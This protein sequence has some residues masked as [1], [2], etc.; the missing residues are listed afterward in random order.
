MQLIT[1]VAVVGYLGQRNS[2]NAVQDLATQLMEKAA[3]QVSLELQDYLESPHELQ[4]TILDAAELGFLDWSNLP[5]SGKYLWKKIQ[6]FDAVSYVGYA[7]K[8]GSFA[9]AGEFL[10]GQGVTIDE[11]SPATDGNNHTFSTNELGERTEVVKIYTPEE[12]TPQTDEWFT[13]TWEKQSPTWGSIYVWPDDPDVVTIPFSQPILDQQNQPIGVLNTDISLT[14]ISQFLQEIDLS[15]SSEIFIL[16]RNGQLV[17][18]SEPGN[19]FHMVD[20]QAQR[21][22]AIDSKNPQIQAVANFLTTQFPNLATLDNAEFLKFKALDQVQYAKVMPWQNDL[23][24]DWLVVATLPESDFMAQIHAN[25]RK[26]FWLCVGAAFLSSLLGMWTANRL[27]SPILTLRDAS[28]NFSKGHPLEKMPPSHI[29]EL[30]DLGN[31][32]NQMAV[33][34]QKS[35]EALQQSNAE[36]ENRVQERTFELSDALQKLKRTQAQML[37]SEKMSALGHLVAGVAHEINNPISFIHGNVQPTKDYIQDLLALLQLY[38]KT[39]TPPSEEIREATKSL[40]LDFLVQ[41]LEKIL[42]SMGDGTNRIQNIVL[43]LR[44]FSRLDEAEFKLVNIHE[45]LDNTLVI[46]QHRLQETTK[47]PQILLIKDYDELPFVNCAAG[48]LNQVFM[49]ILTNAIDFLEQ[50]YQRQSSFQTNDWT[51]EITIRTS[52][53][54]DKWVQIAIADNGPGIPEDILTH[55]F[56]P[57]FS[58]KPIGKGTGMGLAISSQIISDLHNGVLKCSSKLGHGTEFVVEIPIT[59]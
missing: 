39:Y 36:L 47:R 9:G 19:P 12:W 28:Q 53:L 56:D 3:T 14:R 51:P 29:M 18:H 44:N 31:A 54:E 15:P 32:F 25:T 49:N 22:A 37:Q 17:A 2:Q 34:L 11:I 55:I 52:V 35:L 23:G 42:T 46:L 8:S 43:S 48:A 26:T 21:L 24:L 1:A 59:G 20:G 13:K 57:F 16:E 5:D 45:G 41:D 6:Q 33:Q 30:Q 38:Q 10:K 40:D 4:A 7:L 58:T 50:D 27:A